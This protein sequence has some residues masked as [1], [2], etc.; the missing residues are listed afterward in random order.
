MRGPVP[1]LLA[2]GGVLLVI[3][4]VALIGNRDKSGD[5]VTAGEW[6]Q[7]VCGAVGTWRGDLEAIV[8][9]IRTPPSLGATGSEEP[10]SET[11]QGRTGFI[12]SGVERAVQSAD[13]MVEGIDRAGTPETS[14]GEQAQ[15]QVSDW[16][17]SAHQAL[18]NAQ[19]SLDEEAETIGDSIAQ[20]ASAAG[21][22][23]VTIA[24]GVRT[25]ADVARLD[26]ELG[27]AIRDSSTCQELRRKEAA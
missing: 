8:E 23:R 15:Q 11:P 12:R 22:I 5:T 24:E 4:V 10:Q 7:S 26:P 6:A 21:A 19:D 9:D 3:V 16:A 13:T 17:D 18:E 25:L 1:W 27:Q 14:Q 20:L 2:A